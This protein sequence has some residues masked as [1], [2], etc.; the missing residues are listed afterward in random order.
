[1]TGS[2]DSCK[3]WQ[4]VGASHH[5][6]LIV[7][8]AWTESHHISLCSALHVWTTAIVS[9]SHG[10]LNAAAWIRG[11]RAEA[12]AVPASA[13]ISSLSSLSFSWSK[14]ATCSLVD[15]WMSR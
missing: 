10:F 5:T 9:V 14:E 3:L 11:D 7:A 8:L 15:T 2:S 13:A 1:M 6:L 4:S 12:S